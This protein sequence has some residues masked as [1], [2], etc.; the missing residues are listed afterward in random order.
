MV[1]VAGS[2]STKRLVPTSAAFR[3]LR[4]FDGLTRVHMTRHRP[5]RS[6]LPQQRVVGEQAARFGARAA[7]ALAAR[8]VTLIHKL[9][10]LRYFLTTL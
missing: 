7:D 5:I 3:L 6:D 1:Q 10:S 8:S 4:D 9:D 2:I